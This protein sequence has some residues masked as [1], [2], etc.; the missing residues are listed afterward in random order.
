MVIK[1]KQKV[2]CFLLLF[3]LLQFFSCNNQKNDEETYFLIPEGCECIEIFNADS[4]GMDVRYMFRELVDDQPVLVAL[5]FISPLDD[6]LHTTARLPFDM[7]ISDIHWIEGECFFSSDSTIYYSEMNGTV[8][9]IIKTGKMIRSFIM[10]NE[11]ILF[12]EDSLLIEYTYGA[13]E[14]NCIV[15]AHQ[16]ISCLYA[17]EPAVFYS[18]GSDVVMLYENTAYHIFDAQEFI[19]SFV[20]HQNGDLFIGTLTGLSYL[21]PEYEIVRI[22]NKPVSELELIDD[23]L[24]VIFDDNSSVKITNVSNYRSTIKTF[25]DSINEKQD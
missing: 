9:P 18:S 20:V 13:N 5:N 21:N 4:L 7:S 6:S 2:R 8:H 22:T 11:S 3:V 17:I 19:T 1:A 24:Y 16:S 23:V 14:L 10:A 12:P 15:N 25:H